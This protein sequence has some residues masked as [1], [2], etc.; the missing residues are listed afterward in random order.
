MKKTIDKALL[1]KIIVTL[2]AILIGVVSFTRVAGAT[3]SAVNHKHEIEQLD[4]KIDNAMLLTASAAT[5]STVISLLPDDAGTPIASEVA[6]IAKAFVVVLAALYL[7]KYLIT[8]MGF[9]AFG[10]V[11]PLAC[12]IWIIGYWRDKETTRV[13][14]ARMLVCALILY[15]AIPLSVKVSDVI[16]DTY[17]ASLTQTIEASE[18]IGY[19][20]ESDD[21]GFMEKVTN[22][23]VNAADN[24]LS[25]VQDIFKHIIEAFAVMLVT[26]CVIPILIIVVTF[27]LMKVILNLPVNPSE[28][29]KWLRKCMPTL[30]KGKE[31][32]TMAI[33]EK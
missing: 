26:S 15:F 10:I 5:V 3:S 20:Q 12:L 25:Y 19:K 33:D 17:E 8:L 11:I 4:K 32:E 7:E 24:A 18:S 21:A 14:S 1:K 27:W 2:V 6:E 9:L 31:K 16:Y 13:F 22:W 23:I 30:L 28:D 29:L